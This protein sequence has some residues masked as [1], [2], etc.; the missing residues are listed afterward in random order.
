MLNV[1]DL[2]LQLVYKAT[3]NGFKE[4][5]F[6]SLCDNKCPT[7]SVIK[8]EHN[9]TFGGYTDLPWHSQNSHIPGNG[10]SF[11]FQLDSNTKH[12]CINKDY[13][14]FGCNYYSVFFGGGSDFA[15]SDNSDR[16]LSS[17]SNLG[18]SY[19]LPQGVEK[20]SKEALSYLAG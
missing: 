17:V 20:N 9:R 13:E 18:D 14:L 5:D 4:S 3:K 6:H 15:I 8:S 16:N 19:A 7:I 2:K 12:P 11:I 10:N 1:P